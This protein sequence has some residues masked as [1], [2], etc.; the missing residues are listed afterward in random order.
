MVAEDAAIPGPTLA[1]SARSVKSSRIREEQGETATGKVAT[2]VVE[3]TDRPTL[4]GFVADHTE[5]ETTMVFTDE[6][7]GYKGMVNHVAVPHSHGEYVHGE[8]HTNG[9]ESHFSMFK[10]GIIGT[11]HHISPKHTERYATEFAGRHNQRPLDTEEQMASLVRGA[12]GKH[13]PYAALIA[14]PPAGS[15]QPSLL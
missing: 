10:R 12:N 14:E 7:A 6:H 15:F 13:L 11:Y 5:D 1:E 9:V 8:V 2:R 4:I 3:K